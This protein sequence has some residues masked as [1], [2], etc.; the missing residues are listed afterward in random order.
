MWYLKTGQNK[1]PHKSTAH[2]TAGGFGNMN[3]EGESFIWEMKLFRS[4]QMSSANC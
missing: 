1:N 4:Q 3:S 2:Q